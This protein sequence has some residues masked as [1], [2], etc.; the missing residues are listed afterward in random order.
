[1]VEENPGSL[2]AQT[3]ND[4]Q[5]MPDTTQLLAALDFAAHKHRD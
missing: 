3:K 5:H 2:M 4:S 1:M